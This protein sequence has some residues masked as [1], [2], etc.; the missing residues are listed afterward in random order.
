MINMKIFDIQNIKIRRTITICFIIF[1]TILF[2]TMPVRAANV[3]KVEIHGIVFDEK[4]S[5]YNSTL[6]WNAINFTGFWYNFASGKSSEILTIAQNAS[7]MNSSNRTISEGNLL[8]NTSRTDQTYTVFKETGNKV[9]NGLIYDSSNKTFTKNTTG[10]HYA[11]LGWFGDLHTAVNGKANKLT[12]VIKEQTKSEKQTLTIVEKW[13]LGE[14]FS[15]T[16]SEIDA[17]TSPRQAHIVLSKD[18][19]KLDDKIL[20]EREVYTY[21]QN[22]N[23]E[24]EVPVFVTYVDSIFTGATADIV[25]LKYTWLIS[26]NVKEIKTGDKF[27][28]FEVTEANENYLL[29][30]NSAAI[31]LNPNSVIDLSGG[32]KIKVADSSSTLRFYPIIE[33]TLPGK[34]E[35]RGGIYE[36]SKYTNLTWDAQRFPAFWYNLVSGKS[37]ENLIINQ[38]ASNLTNVSRVIEEGILQYNTSRLSQNYTVY[39]EKGL[40]VEKGLVYN[41]INKTFTNSMTGGHYA[42]LGWFGTIHIAL[43]GKANKL[44][45]VIKEQTKSEKQTLTIVE[46]WDLGE[47]FSLTAS[48]IDAKTSPRQAH[49]VFSKDG[50]KLDDKIVTEGQV[51]TYI[52]SLYG[53]TDVPVFVT[54]IDSIF[55]G[56]TSDIVQLRYTWLISRNVI[57]VKNGDKFG[58]FEV[59]EATEDYLLL[60]NSVPISLNQNAIIDLA[61]GIKFKVADSSTVLRFYPFVENTIQATP[62]PAKTTNI[63]EAQGTNITTTNTTANITTS[64]IP[65]NTTSGSPSADSAELKAPETTVPI[66]SAANTPAPRLPG[67]DAF[68]SVAVLRAYPINRR[69]MTL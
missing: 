69:T 4:S 61:E 23:G 53:E 3:T 19:I 35:I 55:T 47:G 43:N 52:Q 9:E 2:L 68:L 5:I 50:N 64:D 26:Q 13:D 16:A 65:D 8:Y 40:K 46:K 12:K 17:K 1:A 22:L 37:T 20:I 32:I 15:L 57:E 39:S 30:K 18:G 66:K 31:N 59:N 60:Q 34:Y 28:I 25:Q 48:E 6:Q 44:T 11:R 27:G 33:K 7:D 54:Y 45:K 24:S 63:S 42:R 38:N 56:A 36:Q 10:S 67:F 21:V 14:G 58:I 51:Y 41:S 62:E 49:L 29:L